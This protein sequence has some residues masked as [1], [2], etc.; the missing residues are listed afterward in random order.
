MDKINNLTLNDEKISFFANNNLI[1]SASISSIE[2][3]YHIFLINCF[4]K[5]ILT[6]NETRNPNNELNK[7]I[8]EL[9]A[10][11]VNNEITKTQGKVIYRL[12]FTPL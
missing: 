11:I 1:W 6:K 12:M 2:T 7:I 5:L 10:A 3:K 4:K 8:Q 9:R